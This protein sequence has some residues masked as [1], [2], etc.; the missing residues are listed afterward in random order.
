MA[1]IPVWL[2]YAING[3]TGIPPSSTV[4][5]NNF[6]TYG[7][8]QFKLKARVRVTRVYFV[9][10]SSR[11]FFKIVHVCRQLH[12]NLACHTHTCDVAK[13]ARVRMCMHARAPSRKEFRS[14]RVTLFSV[15]AH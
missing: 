4:R 14:P 5:H 12:E 10:S 11:V 13:H 2:Q 7:T 9:R 3:I 8:A 1:S 15:Q 6:F